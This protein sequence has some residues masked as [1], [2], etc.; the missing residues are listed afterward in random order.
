LKRFGH[1]DITSGDSKENDKKKNPKTNKI[2]RENIS[3]PSM[4]GT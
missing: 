1:N 4:P 3:P 2:E